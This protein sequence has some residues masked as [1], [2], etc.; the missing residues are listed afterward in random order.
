MTE[1]P[2]PAPETRRFGRCLPCALVL[3]GPCLLGW[4]AL[5][6]FWRSEIVSVRASL[7]ARQAPLAPV[8]TRVELLL[9]AGELLEQLPVGDGVALLQGSSLDLLRAALE[10]PDS[11][12]GAVVYEEMSDGD[13]AELAE[14]LAAL[15]RA[16]R[17]VD[18]LVDSLT[19][20]DWRE[21][22]RERFP[23]PEGSD[24]AGD[25]LHLLSVQRRLLT[26]AACL[27]LEGD[28]EGAWRQIERML[29]LAS[30]C[31]RPT[32]VAAH[33]VTQGV[34]GCVQRAV[35]S[36]IAESGAPERARLRRVRAARAPAQRPHW[37]HRHSNHAGHHDRQVPKV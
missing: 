22:A 15:G 25:G 35:L 3:L 27:Q 7:E 37:P 18:E 14:A 1:A 12:T 26:R 17:D 6:A 31:A 13:P 20:R 9:R 24:E 30:H 10:D 28:T 21:L 23:W 5:R 32:H 34:V 11:E 33:R 36:Q 4:L 19:E 2:Q 29:A 8:S 16:S